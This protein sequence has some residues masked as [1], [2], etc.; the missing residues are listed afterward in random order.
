MKVIGTGHVHLYE[1][2]ADECPHAPDDEPL[3]QE[4]WALFVW[5]PKQRVFVFLRLGQ[6]PNRGAGY[7]SAWINVWTP[8]YLLKHTDDSIPIKPGDSQERSFSAG[9][10]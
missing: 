1:E 6:E 7:T 9:G 4:S 5:D 10:G 2:A 8:E 3:W